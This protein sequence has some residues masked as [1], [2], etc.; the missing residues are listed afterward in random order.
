MISG[1]FF[2][3][4]IFQFGLGFPLRPPKLH[5]T[6]SLRR[7]DLGLGLW[8]CLLVLFGMCHVPLASAGSGTIELSRARE[9]GWVLDVKGAPLAEVFR[10]LSE[11]MGVPIV[12]APPPEAP[13]TLR[14]SGGDVRVIV[15]CLLGSGAS[16]VYHMGLPGH[17]D[18]VSSVR[19][20][21]S[22]YV[23]KPVRNV[24]ADP[25]KLAAILEMTRSEDPDARADGY[26]QLAQLVG[27]NETLQRS[28]FHQGLQDGFGEVRAAALL[29]LHGVDPQGSREE[30]LKGLSDV[31]ANVRLAALDVIGEGAEAE[32]FLRQA[33]NDPDDMV[34]ELARLRLELPEN[35]EH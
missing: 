26:T 1:M 16:V 4:L 12:T 20:L 7:V 6:S 2:A 27:G 22:S 13:L 19:I 11:R 25:S 14:C 32:G 29:G 9:T 21:G 31:D 18:V 35:N 10:T 8:L 30:M 24:N 28:V 17:R 15:G 3:D 33:L 23:R 34:R 5:V